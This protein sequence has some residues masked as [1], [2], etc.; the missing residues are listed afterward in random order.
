MA[1]E[2]K[3]RRRRNRVKKI[4]SRSVEERKRVRRMNVGEKRRKLGQG[5]RRKRRRGKRVRRIDRKTL[6]ESERG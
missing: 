3:K 5:R 4:D 6:W 2:K 1:R